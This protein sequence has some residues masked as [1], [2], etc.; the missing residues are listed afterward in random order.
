[1]YYVVCSFHERPLCVVAT[2][3]GPLGDAVFLRRRLAVCKHFIT[4]PPKM[5]DKDL[6]WT[7]PLKEPALTRLLVYLRRGASLSSAADK[8]V[9]SGPLYGLLCLLSGLISLLSR[10][11]PSPPPPSRP[12]CLPPSL[13]N[14]DARPSVIVKMKK[15]W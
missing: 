10:Y 7:D 15:G 5:R 12:P 3:A 9:I 1:M 11:T 8:R 4:F 14:S 13:I 6:F 2:N